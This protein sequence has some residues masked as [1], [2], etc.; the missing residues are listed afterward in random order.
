MRYE[1]TIEGILRRVIPGA[2]VER[3]LLDNLL[4]DRPRPE[5][6][7][8]LLGSAQPESVRT[9]IL[10]LGLYGSMRESAVLA[11][12][13]HHED[14]SVV[15]LAEHCLWSIWM[16]GGSEQGNRRLAVAI[17]CMKTGADHEAVELLSQLV[18]DEPSFAEAH[19]QRGLALC[20]VGRP[21]EAV[22]AYRQALRLNPY[23]FGAAA[24]LGHAYV[25]LGN[26]AAAL[27]YY[28]QALRIHPRLE[29]LP[30]AIRQVE[31]ALGLRT[32]QQP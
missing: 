29:D 32:D 23:H 5:S 8:S 20:S 10:Y 6:V 2:G 4:R 18:A 22:L 13:L 17:G 15:R 26:L 25:E 12:C 3:T 24:A 9:A 16:Q 19:F 1:A 30:Q 14:P 21:A 31:S 11:L 28:R 27:H 7:I